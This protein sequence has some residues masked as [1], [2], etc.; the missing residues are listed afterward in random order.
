[1]FDRR[2]AA[3]Q[4][5]ELQRAS[6]EA[7]KAQEALT[8]QVAALER[9]KATAAGRANKLAQQLRSERDALQQRLQV[10]GGDGYR[11]LL[12]YI[13]IRSIMRHTHRFPP[14]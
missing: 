11:R 2:C 5:A 12:L 7:A 13:N 9:E 10:C 8:G 3:L 6:E 4:V 14:L 1:M